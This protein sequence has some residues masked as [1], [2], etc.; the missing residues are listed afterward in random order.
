MQTATWHDFTEAL[1]DHGVT[2][3]PLGVACAFLGLA[4]AVRELT[5]KD[6][7]AAVQWIEKIATEVLNFSAC[8]PCP[9]LAAIH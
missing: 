8:A 7:G 4:D 5:K 9:T 2:G 1:S 6:H 3:D